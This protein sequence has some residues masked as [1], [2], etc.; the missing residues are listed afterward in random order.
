MKKLSL[1]LLLVVCFT[2]ALTGC[3]GGEKKTEAPKE[4]HLSDLVMQHKRERNPYYENLSH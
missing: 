1:M 2:L 4:Q 3:G